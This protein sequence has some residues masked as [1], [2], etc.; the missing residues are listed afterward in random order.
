MKV[1][2]EVCQK[3][4]CVDSNWIRI[5]F[6]VFIQLCKVRNMPLDLYLKVCYVYASSKYIYNW[7][8]FAAVQSIYFILATVSNRLQHKIQP[9]K[10]LH[11][12]K[13][14]AQNACSKYCAHLESTSRKL[15]YAAAQIIVRHNLKGGTETIIVCDI[16]LLARFAA[17]R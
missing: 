11:T 7:R 4:M 1:S 12:I 6:F 16:K 14:I 15:H 17:S 9:H 3:C 5:E 2:L 8:G 10:E 13:T